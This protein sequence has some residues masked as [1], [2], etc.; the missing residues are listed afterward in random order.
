MLAAGLSFQERLTAH[1]SLKLFQKSL[2]CTFSRVL[3]NKQQ[4][5]ESG[6]PLAPELQS[7]YGSV[8]ALAQ[9]FVKI[10][11]QSIKQASTCCCVV[12]APTGLQ[13][14]FAK[15]SYEIVDGNT[16]RCPLV[17]LQHHL[18]QPAK[19][20]VSPGSLLL[21]CTVCVRGRRS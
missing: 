6:A 9:E 15:G 13:E 18:V 12:S 10:L 17:T 19:P 21:H 5:Q 20:L 16:Q 8:A 7:C 3:F 11:H 4:T 2:N 14:A 1:R